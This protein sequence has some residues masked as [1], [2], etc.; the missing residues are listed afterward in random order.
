MSQPNIDQ[1][2]ERARRLLVLLNTP[3]PG[4]ISWNIEYQ[5]VMREIAEFIPP[6]VLTEIA[7]K[8]KKSGL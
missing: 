6:D 4:L 5:K 3:Q 8:Q 1:L 2:R 7:R